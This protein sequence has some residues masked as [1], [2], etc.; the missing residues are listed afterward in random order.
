M[1]AWIV[2]EERPKARRVIPIEGE[3][4]FIG[5]DPSC[6]VVIPHRPVS[7]KHARISREGRRYRLED[8]GSR[9]GTWLNGER[10]TPA[11]GGEDANTYLLS[12]GD[13]ITVAGATVLAFNDPDATPLE[14]AMP[15]AARGLRLDEARR[16][17]WMGNRRLEPPVPPAQFILLRLLLAR[18]GAVCSREEIISAVWPKGSA[19]VS[20]DAVDGLVK[21]L[22]ARLKEIAPD[23]ALIQ[24]VRGHGLKLTGEDSRDPDPSRA[25][26]T[27]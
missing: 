19:G 22:R 25:R 21:R 7:R 23:V 26:R 4:L 13:Q 8:L 15:P 5:R 20:D 16:D 12:D 14:I 2:I 1:S 17:V 9:N 3:S 11:K 18:A 10:L 24:S 27:G 6:D